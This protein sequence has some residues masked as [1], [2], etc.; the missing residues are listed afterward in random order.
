MWLFPSLLPKQLREN[1]LCDS[2]FVP[3][4]IMV[5]GDEEASPRA[6]TWRLFVTHVEHGY[7]V[8][9]RSIGVVCVSQSPGP[10]LLISS[11]F[12]L[13]PAIKKTG[14]GISLRKVCLRVVYIRIYAI[15][16]LFPSLLP[17]SRRTEGV[18]AY[19]AVCVALVVFEAFVDT[20]H[21]P[22][23]GESSL[24][25]PWMVCRW[26]VRVLCAGSRIR[27]M[28]SLL[29]FALR[30]PRVCSCCSCYFLPLPVFSAVLTIPFVLFMGLLVSL[31]VCW[32]VFAYVRC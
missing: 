7:S 24:C 29:H 30:P 22:H 23:I 25:A 32:R 18:F 10:R 16:L 3:F 31:V 12:H 26:T 11:V 6:P 28:R 2:H 21:S 8:A 5:V 27:E 1:R 9:D 4:R 13:P 15:V 20:V 19:V 14:L 17:D